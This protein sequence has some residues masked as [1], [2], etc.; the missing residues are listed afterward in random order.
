MIKASVIKI[1]LPSLWILTYLIVVGVFSK[2]GSMPEL[3]PSC[4]AIYLLLQNKSIE[5]ESVLQVRGRNFSNPTE[6]INFAA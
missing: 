4:R 3:F 6:L 1:N 2:N 5:K